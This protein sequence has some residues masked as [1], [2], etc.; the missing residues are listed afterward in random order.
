MQSNQEASIERENEFRER[1]EELSPSCKLVAYVLVDETHLTPEALAEETLL[2]KRTVRYALNRLME[3][4]LVDSSIYI[5]DPRK[6][7]YYIDH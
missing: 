5:E 4:N 7:V 3:S 6:N 1:L 2:P